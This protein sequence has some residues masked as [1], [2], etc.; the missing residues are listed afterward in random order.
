M[1][2]NDMRIIADEIWRYILEK[3][4]KPYL[5]DSLCYYQATVTTAPANGSIGVQRAFDNAVTIPCAANAS[6][7]QVGDTCTVLVFGD[8]SN[9]LAIGNPAN[10]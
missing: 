8:Y 6:A 5:A 3:H 7:L 9:Q 1:G 10:L 2:E 4:L